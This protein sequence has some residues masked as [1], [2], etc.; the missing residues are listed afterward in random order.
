VVL[1]DRLRHRQRHG[2]GLVRCHSTLARYAA[3]LWSSRTVRRWRSSAFPKEPPSAQIGDSESPKITAQDA[4]GVR[5]T[6]LSTDIA[7]TL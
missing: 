2:P 5:A 4:R 6:T 1:L 7:R 3:G